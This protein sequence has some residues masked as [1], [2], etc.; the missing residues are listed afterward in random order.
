MVPRIA[1][2]VAD[3]V[4]TESQIAHRII[5]AVKMARLTKVHAISRRTCVDLGE[6]FG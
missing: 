5:Y 3:I 2:N 4:A 6:V 1:L